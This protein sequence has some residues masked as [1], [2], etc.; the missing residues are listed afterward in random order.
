MI[1]TTFTHIIVMLFDRGEEGEEL[2]RGIIDYSGASFCV[3]TELN[4]RVQCDV[5]FTPVDENV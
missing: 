3:S 1:M 5:N 4:C 2:M